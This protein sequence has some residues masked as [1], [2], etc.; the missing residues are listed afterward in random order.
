MSYNPISFD[1]IRQ[2]LSWSNLPTPTL[3][4]VSSYKLPDGTQ[5]AIYRA[6]W[7]YESVYLW[8]KPEDKFTVVELKAFIEAVTNSFCE[9]ITCL[10]WGWDDVSQSMAIDLHVRVPK[11]ESVN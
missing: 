11:R 2:A 7:S 5:T 8:S 4:K 6:I 10:Q 9:D 3:T 1:V